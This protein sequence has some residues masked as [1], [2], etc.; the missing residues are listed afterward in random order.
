MLDIHWHPV[1]V[2]FPVALFIT[3][4]VLQAVS[5]V[6]KN[7]NANKSALTIYVFAAIVTP[8]AVLSGW[9]E[10]DRLHLHHAILYAHRNFAFMTSGISLISLP[11]LWFIQ[12]KY[13]AYVQ[14]VFLIFTFLAA[15]CVASAGSYGG[16]MVHEYGIGVE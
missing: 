4:F 10:A 5:L 3:A 1:L 8:L 13:P 2:H 6:L 9:L 12:K 16:M 15:G 7:V 11:A 14:I